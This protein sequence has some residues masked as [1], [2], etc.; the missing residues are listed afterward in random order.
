MLLGMP[1]DLIENNHFTAG[2]DDALFVVPPHH[3]LLLH[4]VE[5]ER[6]VAHLQRE[7]ERKGKKRR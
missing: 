3:V 6:V 4:T 7:K 1:H 5:Q 2:R